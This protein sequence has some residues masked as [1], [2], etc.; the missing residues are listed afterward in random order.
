MLTDYYF[1]G[2]F[3]TVSIIDDEYGEIELGMK[4]GYIYNEALHA[5]LDYYKY[6]FPNVILKF[7]KICCRKSVFISMKDAYNWFKEI[8][9]RFSEYSEQLE[10]YLILL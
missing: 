4:Q 10:K 3:N 6:P 7:M 8:D 5:I 2:D 1:K 9:E